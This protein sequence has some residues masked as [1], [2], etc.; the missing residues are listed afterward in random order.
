M[1]VI[2]M[3]SDKL[4]LHV[5]GMD[6]LWAAKSSLEIPKDHIAG[7]QEGV[8]PS[9]KEALSGSLRFGTRLPG[10]ITAGRYYQDGKVMFWDIH[11]GTKAISIQVTHDA[12][13][14]LVVEVEDPKA[15]VQQLRDWVAK[16]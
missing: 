13:T 4:I 2:E 16:K 5:K 15:T 6:K 1:V 11:E 3:T 10:V 7:A 12:Y 8:D 9:A 14:H